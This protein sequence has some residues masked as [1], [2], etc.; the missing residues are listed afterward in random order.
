MLRLLEIPAKGVKFLLKNDLARNQVVPLL[1]PT[2]CE[3]AEI[4]VLEEE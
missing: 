1:S 2:P 4:K 3:A